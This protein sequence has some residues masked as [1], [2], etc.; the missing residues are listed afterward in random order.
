MGKTAFRAHELFLLKNWA[1]ACH[2]EK[3]MKEVRNKYE[4]I[5]ALVIDEVQKKHK[6]LSCKKINLS[7]DLGYNVGIGKKS[8]SSKDSRWPSGLWFAYLRLEN[9][10]DEKEKPPKGAIWIYPEKKVEIDPQ[11]WVT[12]LEKAKNNLRKENALSEEQFHSLTVY[13]EAKRMDVVLMN[14][15]FPESRQTLLDLLL[16]DEPGFI[17][18]L[19]AHF[20]LLALFIPAVDEIFELIK[21]KSGRTM[22]SGTA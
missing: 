15:P 1:E 8:W 5:I 18:R 22:S 4:G 13:G 11:Q 17:S 10:T 19:V 2:A 9:L 14:F 7:N 20:E 16:N 6:E 12:I 3:T 21:Q